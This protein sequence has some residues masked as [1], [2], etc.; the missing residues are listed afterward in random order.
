VAGVNGAARPSTGRHGMRTSG[1][2]SCIRRSAR[3][4][5][6]ARQSPSGTGTA[7]PS[8]APRFPAVTSLHPLGPPGTNSE[9]AAQEWFAIE[10]RP[11][12]V[13][14]HATL[15]AAAAEAAR[16][17]GAAQMVPV[18]YPNLHPLVYAH[19]DEADGC[20]TTLP[21]MESNRLELVRDTD[22]SSWRSPST[23]AG[24]A[25]EPSDAELVRAPR[26]GSRQ[27]P[28]GVDRLFA[29]GALRM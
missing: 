23:S 8:S 10:R 14:L 28:N 1:P 24:I 18:A 26:A 4:D 2:S 5:D 3:A 27:G 13:V 11:G 15:E 22:P 12:K 16:T 19:L 29:D 9:L 17:P 6:A 25:V 20:I 21:A 7:G